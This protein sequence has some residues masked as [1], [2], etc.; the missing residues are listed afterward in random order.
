MSR[1]SVVRAWLV[2]H[3]GFLVGS[4]MLLTALG[5][6]WGATWLLP[7]PGTPR[8]VPFWQLTPALLAMLAS[9]ATVNRLPVGPGRAQRLARAAWALVVIGAAAGCAAVVGLGTGLPSL[10]PGTAA[11]VGLTVAVAALAGRAAVWVGAGW[12]AIV[13]MRVNKVAATEDLW[14]G[15]P[16]RARLALLVVVALGLVGYA[17]AGVRYP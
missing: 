3:E 4:A 14:S 7:V 16:D 17:R 13:L 6:R 11:A 5:I 12:A 2:A 10:V 9:I 15:L 1:P 8:R